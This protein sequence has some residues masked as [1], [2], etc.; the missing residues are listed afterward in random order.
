MGPVIFICIK[1]LWESA[2]FLFVLLSFQ[3]LE[4][5]IMIGN[6]LYHY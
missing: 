3:L 4:Q 6:D 2:P 1:Q 5:F